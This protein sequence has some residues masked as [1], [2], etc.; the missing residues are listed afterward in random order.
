MN[1]NI[2]LVT[3]LAAAAIA[4]TACGDASSP[5][6]SRTAPAG[7]STPA[8]VAGSPPPATGTATS[9]TSPA[10]A[11]PAAC[12]RR[13]LDAIPGPG[14]PGEVA[15]NADGD[16]VPDRAYTLPFPD[17]ARESLPVSVHVVVGEQGGVGVVLPVMNVPLAAIGGYDVD[18]D[19]R[20]ELF[21][22]TGEG[23]YTSWIDVFEFDPVACALTRLAAPG[24]TL[25]QFAVGASVGNGS[26][27]ACTGGKFVSSTMSRISDEPLRYHVRSRTYVIDGDALRPTNTSERDTDAEGAAA[28]SVF[29]CG[30][31]R[32]PGAR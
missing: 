29:D 13:T 16:H 26:G 19:G 8:T 1:S 4:L 12:T 17:H 15:L 27:L 6:P 5:S 7:T 24:A 21:V 25:P 23:A 32:L 22:K 11:V 3:L 10:A 9:S 28:A 31:L 18:G 30:G 2:A 20:D 14:V